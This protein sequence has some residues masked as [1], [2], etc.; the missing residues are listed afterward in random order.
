MYRRVRIEKYKIFHRVPVYK[1]GTLT[2][3]LDVGFCLM[4]AS[5]TIFTA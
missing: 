2:P 1:S 3:A 4:L 5:I